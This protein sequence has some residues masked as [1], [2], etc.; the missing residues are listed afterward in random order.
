MVLW[1]QKG[2]DVKIETRKVYICA[3]SEEHVMFVGPFDTEMDAST[4]G[5]KHLVNPCWNVV[6]LY[7]RDVAMPLD[8]VTP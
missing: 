2:N 8:L 3:V 4:W 6:S 7:P 5:A 1:T